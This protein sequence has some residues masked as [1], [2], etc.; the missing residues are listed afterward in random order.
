MF[1]RVVLAISLLA[2]AVT[3]ATIS[4]HPVHALPDA[5]SFADQIFAALNQY[6]TNAGLKP[7]TRSATL[8]AGAREWSAYIGARRC[9]GGALICHRSKS[10]ISALA[11]SA[12]PGGAATQR[13][14]KDGLRLARKACTPSR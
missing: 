6:R 14:W 12:S 10:G 13:P 5:G 8:D 11:K 4:P 3:A 9:A 2:G 7:L 1:K